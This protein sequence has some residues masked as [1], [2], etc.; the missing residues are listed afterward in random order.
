MFCR[1]GNKCPDAM[2]PHIH[3]ASQAASS[4]Y[5]FQDMNVDESSQA[6]FSLDNQPDQFQ[7]MNVDESSQASFSL[8]NQPDQF[9][10]M[11]VDE[12]SKASSS[13]QDSYSSLDFLLQIPD[14]DVPPE[15]F[16]LVF[17]RNSSENTSDFENIMKLVQNKYNEIQLSYG[18]LIDVAVHRTSH[19]ATRCFITREFFNELFNDAGTALTHIELQQLQENGILYYISEFN[20]TGIDY[21]DHTFLLIYNAENNVYYLL[22]SYYYAYTFGGKYGFIKLNKKAFDD[23]VTLINEYRSIEQ[24]SDIDPYKKEIIKNLNIRLQQYTG[25]DSTGHELDMRPKEGPNKM[26]IKTKATT[27]ERIL[28]NT[29]RHFNLFLEIISSRLRVGGSHIISSTLDPY[30]IYDS[31]TKGRIQTWDEFVEYTGFSKDVMIREIQFSPPYRYFLIN[32][33]INIHINLIELSRAIRDILNSIDV[34]SSTLTNV[35]SFRHGKKIKQKKQ[36]KKN[37]LKL[38]KRLKTKKTKKTI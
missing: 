20:F 35:R 6:S 4:S 11:N 33:N 16:E 9:Q 18:I 21:P 36:S 23:F 2:C 38:K 19:A 28:G 15:P 37:N 3:P 7:D 13:S 25:I 24:I 8:D 34:Y 1:F 27:L 22:Q 32:S 10:D 30:R 31:F 26:E 12:S 14:I 5:Q 17:L 29:Y